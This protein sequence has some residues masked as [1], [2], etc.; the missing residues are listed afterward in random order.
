M[1][2]GAGADAGV[3]SP[4]AIVLMHKPGASILGRG[5]VPRR[6]GA[7]LAS[8]DALKEGVAWTAHTGEPCWIG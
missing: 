5:R 1:M 2:G 8:Q 6:A 4:A 3:D 7:S